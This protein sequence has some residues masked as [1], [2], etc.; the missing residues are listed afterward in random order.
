MVMEFVI[1]FCILNLIRL[2]VIMSNVIN[3][4]VIIGVISGIGLGLVEV[5]LNEGYNVVGMGCFVECL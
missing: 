1:G 4:V 2:E 3:I 5:F